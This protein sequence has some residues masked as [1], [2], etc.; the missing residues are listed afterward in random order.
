MQRKLI[1]FVILVL[2]A[3]MLFA[4]IS[5]I[6]IKSFQATSE[7]E[8]IRLEW[9][10]SNETE[11]ISYEIFRKSESGSQFYKLSDIVP[12][13]SG[14]YQ[15]MDDELYKNSSVETITYKLMIKSNSQNYE[16]FTSIMYQPTAVQRTWG[17]IKAMFK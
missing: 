17:S 9:R 14:V 4:F 10:L 12:N 8:G 3:G 6:S 11:V 16:Y 7:K 1:F 15:F 2:N 13:G 5:P